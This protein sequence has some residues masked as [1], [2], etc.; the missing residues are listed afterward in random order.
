MSSLTQFARLRNLTMR[1]CEFDV[2]LLAKWIIRLEALE[3]LNTTTAT[4]PPSAA[5]ALAAALMKLPMI[6]DLALCNII[7]AEGWR[8]F[9]RSLLGKLHNLDLSYSWLND[10]K[11]QRLWMQFL[12]PAGN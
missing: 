9:G 2:T 1:N 8:H 4:F 7:G 12:L 11:Y 3:S 5:E 6:T 10:K